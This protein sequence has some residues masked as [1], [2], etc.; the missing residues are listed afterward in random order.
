MFRSNV[1]AK[2]MV[3]AALIVACVWMFTFK[4]F[5]VSPAAQCEQGGKWWDAKDRQCLTPMPIERMTGR[6]TA[7]KR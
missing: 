2:L 6:T 7:P 1:I 4:G 5:E 3:L